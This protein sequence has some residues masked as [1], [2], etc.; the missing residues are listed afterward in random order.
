MKEEFKRKPVIEKELVYRIVGC[1]M[2]VNNEIGHGLREKT[3]ER[4][5]CL[6]LEHEGISYS[7]QT[8]YPV[9]YRGKII[10]EFVPDLAVENK[11][12]VEAK[13]VESIRDEHR[14]Q[15][16]NYLRITGIRVGLI[17]NFRHPKL[18]RERLVLDTARQ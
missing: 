15:L 9:H 17:L 12:I 5:L 8:K 1:A 2:A 3:Y 4:A 13:T 6:E 16:L 11:V 10:D 7:Q 18:E 14:G